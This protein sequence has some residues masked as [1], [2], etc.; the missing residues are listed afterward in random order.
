VEHI[1]ANYPRVY[2]VKYN[3]EIRGAY[4]F[5]SDAEYVQKHHQKGC[6]PFTVSEVESAILDEETLLNI[7]AGKLC[8]HSDNE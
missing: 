1:K 6:I 4:I 5:R 8:E 3:E 2:V 7:H